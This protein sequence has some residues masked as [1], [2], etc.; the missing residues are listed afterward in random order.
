[1]KEFKCFESNECGVADWPDSAVSQWL[2]ANAKVCKLQKKKKDCVG[3][4]EAEQKEEDKDAKRE[5]KK[6]P[7]R[8]RQRQFAAV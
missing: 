1:M 8:D 2:C 3:D 4:R 5:R 7:T 6:R